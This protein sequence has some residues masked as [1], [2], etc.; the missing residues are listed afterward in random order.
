MTE[1]RIPGSDERPTALA[2][3]AGYLADAG[4]PLGLTGS[5]SMGFARRSARFGLHGFAMGPQEAPTPYRYRTG[6]GTASLVHNTALNSTR[7]SGGLRHARKSNC[8]DD[9]TRER[10]PYR[11]SSFQ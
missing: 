11:S 7:Y 6:D 3:L 9:N 1:I 2:A 8:K 4:T 10:R 5:G